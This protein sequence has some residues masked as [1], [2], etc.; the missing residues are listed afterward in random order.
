LQG[1]VITLTKIPAL[2]GIRALAVLLVFLSHA[3]LGGLLP[4]GFGVT[5]FFFLSGYL[6]TTLLRTEYKKNRRISIRFFFIRRF[7]RLSPPL[8]S[9]LFIVYLLTYF[10]I[11][12]GGISINGAL[13]QFLYF[14]NY[15]SIF[16]SGMGDIPIG[17][18][19]L[20][21][22]AVEEHFYILYPVLAVLVLK[23]TSWKQ[24]G[25]LLVCIAFAVF[26]WRVILVLEYTVDDVRTYYATDTRI[27]SILYGCLLAI[28]YNPLKSAGNSRRLS[29]EN[30][31]FF[32]LSLMI[33]AST[34]LYRNPGFRETFRYS[35]QGLALMPLFYLAISKHKNFMFSWL[36][37][38]VIE[39]IGIYSYSIYLIH[40]VV[41]KHSLS[42]SGLGA[43]SVIPVVTS[44]VL[45]IAYAIFIDTFIDRPML[46]VRK[47]YRA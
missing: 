30:F 35:I 5:V 41:L 40:Y 12:P 24:F 38:G 13:A 47:R 22:L 32:V 45:C 4:G 37:N 10:S 36:N 27:D 29:R 8:F 9:T 20:W 11:L 43:Y 21:S 14:T 6:I 3:G 16:F 25:V 28:F 34:F 7:L 18:G 17:T 33:L 15:Y 2:N 42:Y 39:Q 26:L 19:V 31:G 46:K 23:K 44:F 1:A